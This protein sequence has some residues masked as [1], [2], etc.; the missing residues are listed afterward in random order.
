MIKRWKTVCA[1]LALILFI[2]LSA[3]GGEKS[4]I[5]YILDGSGSMWGRVDGKIKIQ[6]AKEVM[7]T[8]IAETPEGIECGVMVYGHRKKGDCS[9]IEMMVPI[10]PLDKTSAV[11]KISGI[12]PK[13]KTPISDSISMAVDKLKGMEAASTIVLVSDGIE[14]CGKDPCDVVKQFKESGINFVMHVVGFDVNAQAADQL[15][16]IA[17]AGGGR[18]FSTTH[19][20]DLLTALNQIRESVAEKKTIE[21]APAPTP[22]PIKQA[23]DKK[24]TSIRI[25]A[26]GPGTLVLKY[27]DWLKPPRYWKLIDPETGEEKACFTGLG[28]QMVAPGEYQIV[29]RQDEHE[30]SDVTLG[31]VIAVESRKTTDVILKTGLRPVTPQWVKKPR[32]WRLK[33][34]ATGKVIAHFGRL[35]PQ[36]VPSGEYELLWRQDEHGS[37]TVT[38]A[39]VTI[40]PDKLNDVKLATAVNPVPAEWVPE[41]LRFWELRDVKTDKPVAH[42]RLGWTPQLVPAG[43]YRF[44]YRQDEHKSSNSDLGEV[45]IEAGKMTD[46]PIN[47]GVK[48]IP[49]P[50][51]KPPYKIEFIELGEKGGPIRT[52]VQQWSFDPML[53]RPGA[54]RITYRQEEHGGSTLTLVDSFELPA[55]ALVEVEM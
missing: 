37:A 6:A 45:T 48:L 29:W 14:T 53:L 40:Q 46:F 47:T 22:E 7:S 16:C 39:K 4:L 15:A 36:L 33:D 27:D 32:F 18:Y 3:L 13:G 38:L 5:V 50:G 30:S 43:T 11:S 55:G 52:V 20:T 49:R 2:P 44:I 28:N 25:K 17:K 35:D 8:L 10:G 21:P 12:T 24:T 54:Y 51:V 23:V 34:P 26:K 9:D 41:R 19:A 1:A 31:E 42:F